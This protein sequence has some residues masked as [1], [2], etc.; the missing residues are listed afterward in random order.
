MFQI[1]ATWL[2]LSTEE[3]C[4]FRY[5]IWSGQP[6]VHSSL[7]KVW[8]AFREVLKELAKFKLWWWINWWTKSTTCQFIWNLFQKNKNLATGT[9][10]HY[11]TFYMAKVDSTWT[12]V[13]KRT[14]PFNW[15]R[16]HV[17]E[18]TQPLSDNWEPCNVG[19]IN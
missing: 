8:Q 19:V 9:V 2:Q 15:S 11:C 7:N 17:V 5:L 10:G 18:V 14:D 4:A 16:N 1:V 12:K 6:T 13:D 3:Y